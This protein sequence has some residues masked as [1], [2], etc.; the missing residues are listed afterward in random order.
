MT[1]IKTTLA[2]QKIIWTGNPH[3]FA[4]IKKQGFRLEET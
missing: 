2:H 4:Q 1:L 3:K